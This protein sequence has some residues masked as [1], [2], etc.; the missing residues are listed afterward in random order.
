MLKEFSNDTPPALGAG[1]GGRR[2][3]DVLAA[4]GRGGVEDL[5]VRGDVDVVALVIFRDA[6]PHVPNLRVGVAGRQGDEVAPADPRAGAAVEVEVHDGLRAGQALERDDVVVVNGSRG[7]RRIV[8]RG[9]FDGAVRRH[10]LLDGHAQAHHL[11]ES[12]GD[13][14][15]RAARPDGLGP[16][17]D[18]FIVEPGIAG[19]RARHARQRFLVEEEEPR[20][21]RAEM[22]LH[23]G[24]VAVRVAL[25]EFHRAARHDAARERET[26]GLARFVDHL[27]EKVR[28]DRQ[29][30]GRTG[31]R[32]LGL[33]RHVARAR[34]SRDRIDD[35]DQPGG[36]A[37]GRGRR[38]HGRRARGRR[39]ERRGGQ[40]RGAAG[41][42]PG[43][44]FRRRLPREDQVAD[45]QAQREQPDERDQKFWTFHKGGKRAGEKLSVLIGLPGWGD[46][47][48]RGCR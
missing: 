41:A 20:R 33:G 45:E 30:R 27:V 36:S 10:G 26:G 32:F 16:V 35:V 39:R 6:L 46:G 23:E 38:G 21:G 1:G 42:R 47:G 34:K 13:E 44:P 5:H 18:L 25:G 2:D 48:R 28:R 4:V 8:L 11:V 14:H 15:R 9:V 29:R 37:R 31:E 3:H 7:V 12:A 17:G 22:P 43:G 19:E 24:K 40:R